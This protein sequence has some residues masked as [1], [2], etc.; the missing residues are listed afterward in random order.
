MRLS[1][2]PPL[3]RELREDREEDRRRLTVWLPTHH[4]QHPEPRTTQEDR[5]NVGVWVANELHH[6]PADGELTAL[7]LR[8]VSLSV[9]LGLPNLLP[10]RLEIGRLDACYWFPRSEPAL[11]FHLVHGEEPPELAG[12]H[13]LSW[14]GAPV[15]KVTPQNTSRSL[16]HPALLVEESF[17]LL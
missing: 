6:S 17:E 8:V 7:G 11:T 4:H 10:H 15:T 2:C 13:K 3:H 14:P 1:E 16:N 9:S 5:V 12:K